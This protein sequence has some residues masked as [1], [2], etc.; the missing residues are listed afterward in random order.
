MVLER[1]NRAELEPVSAT[2]SLRYAHMQPH[3]LYMIC[4][5]KTYASHKAFAECTRNQ[6]RSFTSAWA[7]RN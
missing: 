3:I 7:Y 5:R 1:S 6:V 4:L 2:A